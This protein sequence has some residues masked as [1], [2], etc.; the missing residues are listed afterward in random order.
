MFTL[1][2]IAVAHA[3]V[4]SGA[5]FPLY[6]QTIMT[7]GVTYYETSVADG[8]TVYHG[9]GGYELVSGPKFEMQ[10]ISDLVD[11]AQFKR[12]L[13]HHQ[14]GGSGYR[15]FTKECAANGV[16]KWGVCLDTMTCTYYDKA[17]NKILVEE[18]PD[19]K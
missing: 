10:E 2:Q 7:L 11:E 14:N 8:H 17:G 15:E 1:E 9:K 6:A 19:G 3:Q 16:D 18:I 5:D 4:K 13:I 12:D